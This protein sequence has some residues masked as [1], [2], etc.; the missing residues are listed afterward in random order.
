MHVRKLE[1]FVGLCTLI[2]STVVLKL[3]M[4]LSIDDAANTYLNPLW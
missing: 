4:D 2:T 1:I 3:G